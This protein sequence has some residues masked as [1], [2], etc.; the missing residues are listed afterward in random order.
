MTQLTNGWNVDANCIHIGLVNNMPDSSLE[1]TERQFRALL[2]EASEGG[3]PFH[4]SLFA[5][6]EIPRSE[7]TRQ[8]I[9]NSYI[10]TSA[11]WDLHLDGLIVTGAE[12]IA[13][14]LTSEPFWN[15]MARLVD[16]AE[17]NTYSSIWSC[18][19][20]HAAVL[21][22]DGIKRRPFADKLFGVFEC[23]KISEHSVTNGLPDRFRTPHSRWN[24]LPAQEL[25]AS[26]YRIL[27]QLEDGGPDTFTR[28]KQNQF[29]FLQGHPEYEAVSLLLE[30]RR[31]IRRFL[32]R[33][34]DLYPSMPEGYFDEST[35]DALKALRARVL[36]DRREEHFAAFPPAA[37]HCSWRAQAVQLYRNWL[38]YLSEQKATRLAHKRRRTGYELRT[39]MAAAPGRLAAKAEA[40]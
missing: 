14:D 16:W 33:Q 30:Y 7:K 12:P 25:V 5:I 37:V 27:T 38:S 28:Q 34:R 35:A 19:A 11:L 21:H 8:Q 39:A 31:D 26:G 22:L 40:R 36:S 9:S 6:P 18:L 1:A 24:N 2:F 4:L 29:I 17:H 10:S 13:S 20:A 32:A 3:M 15:S 23:A